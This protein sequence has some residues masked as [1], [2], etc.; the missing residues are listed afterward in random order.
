MRI[1]FIHIFRQRNRD[2]GATIVN[3]LIP[4]CVVEQRQSNDFLI[5]LWLNA[6]FDHPK[7]MLFTTIDINLHIQDHIQIV[8]SHPDTG[9]VNRIVLQSSLKSR[10]GSFFRLR[11]HYRLQRVNDSSSIIRIY[12]IV[13][14]HTS[15]CVRRNA[16]TGTVLR[17]S[18]QLFLIRKQT[19][20]QSIRSSFH[21]NKLQ[22]HRRII[23]IFIIPAGSHQEK[24]SQK[25]D[26]M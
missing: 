11:G 14:Y 26:C 12:F 13:T 19:L 20:Y 21:C 9:H 8:T 1:L 24:H 2:I 16:W 17:N 5:P 15:G 3:L 4:I 6:L 18:Q 25:P 10:I 22:L 23:V 7:N